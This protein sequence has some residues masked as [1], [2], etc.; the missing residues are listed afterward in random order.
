MKRNVAALLALAALAFVAT[1]CKMLKARDNLGQGVKLFKNT[2][3]SQAVEKFEEAVRLDPSFP[4]ARVYLAM[5]YYMQYIPGA[6]SP[7]NQQMADHGRWTW[8]EQA[9]AMR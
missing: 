3:Y 6:E 5:A 2:Q 7:E 8:W 1:G 9:R 4:T